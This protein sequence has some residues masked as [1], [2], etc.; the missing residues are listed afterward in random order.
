MNKLRVMG[1][2]MLLTTLVNSAAYG[3]VKTDREPPVAR[4]ETSGNP[5][6]GRAATL[7][8]TQLI[9]A[10]PRRAEG[11]LSPVVRIVS[12]TAGSVAARGESLVGQGSPNGTAF[13][14]N[15]EVTTRDHVA[16]AAREANSLVPIRH[17]DRLGCPNPDVPGFYA[18]V[19]RDFVT[20]SGEIIP[21]NTNL[22]SLFNI[23]G[24][25]DTPGPGVTLWLGWHVLESFL[26]DA[27]DFDLT[28]AFV[29]QAG[30][31]GFDE[32]RNIRITE[33]AISGQTLTPAVDTFPGAAAK[34]TAEL[35]GAAEQPNP[36]TTNGFGSGSV[37]YNRQTGIATVTVNFQNLSSNQTT[38]HIHGP[39]TPDAAGPVVFDIDTNSTPPTTNT[40]TFVREWA[41]DPVNLERLQNGLLYFNV[42]SM[43]NPGGEVR[44]H[45][46]PVVNEPGAPEVASIAPRVPTAVSL[47]TQDGGL[48]PGNGTLFFIQVSTVDRS[49]AGIAVSENGIRAG[50]TQPVG[51]I[52]DPT[53]IGARGP[54]RNFPGLYVAFDVDLRQPNGNVVKAG[55]NLA[56][57]FDIAGS[58]LDDEGG[59][60]RVTTDWVIGGAL[61]LPAGKR[62][63]TIT[64]RVTDNAGRT[65]ET[66]NIVTVSPA[67]SGQV[68]TTAP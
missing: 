5:R 42:H 54:N 18:F 23:A 51:L 24:T 59:T 19:N 32:I 26:P 33:D 60:V 29:D 53:Q 52:F 16:I 27:E 38:A 15:V 1:L 55:Q 46:R 50:S 34:F 65:G 40:G 7:T 17:V 22:A 4:S 41:I 28:V 67:T 47:G 20:P 48:N 13:L 63:I 35:T 62:S 12:P 30:R 37:F 49:G 64:S 57:L 58:E 31:I 36:V 25:D 8:Y 44:G 39:A 14:F 45:I 3:Q 66:K 43:S 21:R 6:C 11:D 9:K 56:P 61:L 2:A 10:A 68:L